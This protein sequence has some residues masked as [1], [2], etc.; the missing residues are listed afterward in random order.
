MQALQAA[1]ILYCFQGK[2]A[3]W[4]MFE[5]STQAAPLPQMFGLAQVCGAWSPT[6]AGYG[7]GMLCSWVLHLT[8][9]TKMYGR[10]W[11][12]VQQFR[13]LAELPNISYS[14]IIS[15][16]IAQ[17]Q[18]SDKWGRFIML[19][20][21]HCC[22][23]NQALGIQ[24]TAEGNQTSLIGLHCVLA[25]ASIVATS[26]SILRIWDF[27]LH[28]QVMFF[29]ES[30]VGRVPHASRIT[31][32]AHSM[33]S[34]TLSPVSELCANP[35]QWVCRKT[36]P[37]VSKPFQR[38]AAWTASSWA[39]ARPFL[40]PAISLVLCVVWVSQFFTFTNSRWSVDPSH[41]CTVVFMI[42][43]SSVSVFQIEATEMLI[44][45]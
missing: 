34:Q 43:L 13:K 1:P 40:P 20:S 33:G 35:H 21:Q 17:L 7:F 15:P 18:L 41:V 44:F 22:S 11:Y 39:E 10:C 32:F 37:E 19:K 4:F 29:I 8:P 3:K 6:G 27:R 12:I 5:K 2:E 26:K 24:V 30:A 25:S 9:F 45:L 36:F 38:F 14:I 31:T 42:L 16:E 23:A 28:V